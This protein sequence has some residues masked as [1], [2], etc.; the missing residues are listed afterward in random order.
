MVGVHAMVGDGQLLRSY[1][2]AGVYHDCAQTLH[3]EV[4]WLN[5]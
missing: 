1:S 5:L 3:I 4:F 2:A